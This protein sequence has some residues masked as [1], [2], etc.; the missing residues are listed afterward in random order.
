MMKCVIPKEKCLPFA[1]GKTGNC[2]DLKHS[3][4]LCRVVVITDNVPFCQ[5][6]VDA[7]VYGHCFG[8]I[9]F[10]ALS[11]EPRCEFEFEP[12]DN[13]HTNSPPCCELTRCCSTC[14]SRLIY[15]VIISLRFICSGVI[16]GS[17]INDLASTECVLDKED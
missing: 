15:D 7:P 12:D 17:S 11:G 10:D 1:D 13:A 4:V 2:F 6:F 14:D 16:R 5:R 9:A 8:G 3:P